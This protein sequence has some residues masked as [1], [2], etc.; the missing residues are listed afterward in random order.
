MPLFS[1]WRVA[2]WGGGGGGG[3]PRPKW[4]GEN[5]GNE[6]G[7]GGTLIPYLV[8][9]RTEKTGDR[10]NLRCCEGRTACQTGSSRHAGSRRLAYTAKQYIFNKNAAIPE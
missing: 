7:E 1:G 3:Q 9:K 10:L 2:G 5:P 6:V 8:R 4:F